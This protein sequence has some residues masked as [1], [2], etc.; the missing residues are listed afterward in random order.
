MGGP[1]PRCAKAG[2]A[3]RVRMA[4]TTYAAFLMTSRRVS[5]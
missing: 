5:F 3:V 1:E 4:G 2:E